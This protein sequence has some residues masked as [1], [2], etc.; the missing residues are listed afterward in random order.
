MQT[1]YS[2]IIPHYHTPQLLSRCLRSIPQ[3]P[4]VEVLVVDD[5][6]PEVDALKTLCPELLRDDVTLLTTP[7]GGSAGRARNVGIDHARGE[8][9]LFADAD[10]YYVEGFLDVLDRQL[11]DVAGTLDIL[12]YNVAGEGKRARLHRQIFDLYVAHHDDTEVRYHIWAPWN[13]VIARRLIVS[14]QLRFEEVRVGNDALFCL[15]ASRAASRYRII[16]DCLYCLCDNDGSLTFRPQ[17]FGR[18]MD[19]TDVHIR[20]T[21]FM[22]EQGLDLRYGYHVFSIARLRRFAREYGWSEAW[23]YLRL[24]SRGYGLVRALLYNRRRK[25]YQAS[26]PQYLYCD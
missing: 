18:E 16:S 21:R 13:K 6:S 17:S 24:V 4:D 8:W 11:A 12:Y 26:H 20:I 2:I 22:H 5:C 14:H 15:H 7:Q 25:A 10:D 19:Y 23:A 1:R 3:R 9:C